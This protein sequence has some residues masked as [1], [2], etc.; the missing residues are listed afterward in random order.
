MTSTLPVVLIV[1]Q[2]STEIGLAM[3]LLDGIE[4]T[5]KAC[6]NAAEVFQLTLE[7]Q[8]AVVIL[9]S[10]LELKDGY[11]VLNH[12]K[13]QNETAHIPVIFVP[14]N[15][16]ERQMKLHAD[17]IRRVEVLAKPVDEVRYR[18]LVE[19]YLQLYQYRVAIEAIGGEKKNRSLVE[20]RDEGVLVIDE[21]GKICFAN[22]A[23]ER[24]LDT[25]V[26]ALC[27]QYIET[28]LQ[29]SAERLMS[30][31]KDHPISKVTKTEQILQV[32][33]AKIWGATGDVI[34]VK[35]AA[36]PV[37]HLPGA[38]LLFAFRRLK[39]SR[40][41]KGKLSRL[42][43]TDHLTGLPTRIRVDDYI[44]SAIQKAKLENNHFALLF[45]D[46]DHFKYINETLGHDLGD[47]LIKSVAQRVSQLLRKDD[48]VCRMEGDEFVVI[49]G[50][51]DHPTHA[52][53][54][55]KKV[56]D[57]L[58]EPFLVD[59]HEI[60]T[61]C[62]IGVAIYPSC[63]DDTDI[64]IKN[65]EAAVARAK[66]LGRNNY[67][68]YTVEMNKQRADR[69]ELELDLRRALDSSQF[70][71]EYHPLIN[72]EESSIEA[73]EV[74]LVWEHPKRGLLEVDDFLPVAEDAGFGPDLYRW[75]WKRASAELSEHG[76]SLPGMKLCMPISPSLFAQD[77]IVEWL[78]RQ[79][80]KAGL[81]PEDILIQ[82]PESTLM[83][84]GLSFSG[85]I[86]ELQKVGFQFVLDNFGTG[87][88][89]LELIR[90]IPYSMIKIS[91]RFIDKM[92]ESKAD[93]LIVDGIIYLAHNLGFKV[94]A[95]GVKH[96]EQ[97]SFLQSKGCD[98]VE[99]AGVDKDIA[100]ALLEKVPQRFR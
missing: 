66:N 56:I 34:D 17:M 4:A 10:Q 46:L 28:I 25:R 3:E 75:M 6:S 1:D 89:S 81:I 74:R 22:G 27:G 62:S 72:H 45:I 91:E 41:K 51:L 50:E 88:G 55:A 47:A 48:A 21:A 35:F 85:V 78:L 96:A 65:A 40:E 37:F 20:G 38:K 33:S 86:T 93:E 98:W 92:M 11:Q 69:M 59:G 29:D 67:Q 9:S 26:H 7:I 53:A 84:R 12:L 19:F 30:S 44:S 63:G 70:K 43:S 15:F 14:A 13:S 71:L 24:L 52:G 100:K 73:F 61:G 31:W 90:S 57:R 97:L 60:F 64:L 18:G 23:A 82:I 76:K 16:G 77:N 49:L 8:P 68:F 87:H 32:E 58:H 80:E 83:A 5:F 54:V 39:K 94:I 36:I 2:E 99:G 79:V 95:T 42:E